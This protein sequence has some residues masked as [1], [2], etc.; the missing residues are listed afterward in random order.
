[1][2]PD[3]Q[4]IHGHTR[5]LATFSAALA[6]EDLPREVIS[7]VKHLIIDTLG[8]TLAATTLGSGCREVAYGMRELGGKP[9]STILGFGYKV[10][11]LNAAFANGGLAHAL[12]YDPISRETGHVGVVCLTA[13]L[14]MAEALSLVTTRQFLTAATIASE[15]SARVAAAQSRTGKASSVKFMAGQLFGYFG[16]AAAAGSLLQLSAD[17]IHSAFGIALMQASGTM[18]VVHG[19]DPPAKAI[20]GAFPNHGGLLAALLS[21]AGLD[22][23]C[24]ALEGVAGLYEMFYGGEYREEALFENLGRDFLLM[25]TSFKPWATSEIAHPFIEAA[26]KIAERRVDPLA[27][28][29]VNVIGDHHI[30]PWCEPIEERRFPKNAAS[31]GNSIPFAVARALVRGDL[32]LSDFT[33]Q[34]INDPTANA[35]AARIGYTLRAGIKGGLVEVS[36]NDGREHQVHIEE[37]LGHPSR[38]VPY[39][40]LVTKFRDCCRYSVTPLSNDRIDR[41][42]TLIDNLENEDFRTLARL[43]SEQ[44]LV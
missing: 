19:G 43:S 12:N 13:P 8:T 44:G 24:D 33:D 29:A 1:M 28:K 37:P 17:Q 20:Y 7:K 14:A 21:K 32:V 35:L 40:R 3:Y 36:T 10:A 27:I 38:P 16:A 22:G 39:E 23:K 41:L 34:G 4:L 9:E 26:A 31:A 15:I 30:R 11:A 42:I 2:Q 18:Q 25:Q 6:Y 5:R